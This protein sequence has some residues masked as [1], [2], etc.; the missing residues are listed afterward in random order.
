MCGAA[1]E[2]TLVSAFPA[3]GNRRKGSPPMTTIASPAIQSSWNA[4]RF[5]VVALVI[6]A[7]ASLAFVAGRVTHPTR[8]INHVAA[9]SAP[10]FCRSA[11]HG[12]C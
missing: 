5:L 4:V 6:L 2:C 12:A 3:G 8:T 9:A 10:D 11:H 1:S 7:V